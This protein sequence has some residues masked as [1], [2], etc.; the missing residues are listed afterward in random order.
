MESPH[1]ESSEN[2]I[3]FIAGHLTMGNFHKHLRNKTFY[4]Q[5][6]FFKAFNPIVKI[7][8]LPAPVNFLTYGTGN[9]VV[10]IFFDSCLNWLTVLRWC[11]QQ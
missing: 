3:K 2:I 6:C 9:L 1:L 7:E 10:I 8:N 5:S 4:F 11:R